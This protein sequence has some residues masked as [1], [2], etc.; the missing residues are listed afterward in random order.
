M[1]YTKLNAMNYALNV[2]QEKF[3]DMT[4]R[5]PDYEDCR[6]TIQILASQAENLEVSATRR[7]KERDEKW[8]LLFHAIKPYSDEWHTAF[9]LYTLVKDE[10]EYKI[11]FSSFYNRISGCWCISSMKK[12]EQERVYCFRPDRYHGEYGEI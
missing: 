3:K 1:V 9:D 7:K 4:R 6:T 11:N 8:R 5:D 10:I 12:G 2:L